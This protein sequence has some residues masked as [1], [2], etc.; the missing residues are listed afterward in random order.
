MGGLLPALRDPKAG[1][2]FRILPVFVPGDAVLERLSLAVAAVAPHAGAGSADELARLREDPDW[3]ATMLTAP[4]QP[5]ALIVVD[6]FEEVFTLATEADR[7]AL[8]ASLGRLLEADAGHRVVLT[9]REE[10]GSQVVKL[11]GI[12]SFRDRATYSMRPL[13]YEELVAAVSRPAAIVNLQFQPGIVDDLVKKVLGQAAA[14]PLLQFTLRRLWDK[15]DR[16]RITWEVYRA[17]KDP[18]EALKASADAFYES[19][20][21]Q[22]RDEMKRVLLELVRVDDFLEAYRQPLRKAQLL[23]AGRANTAEVLGLLAENDYLRITPGAADADTV[24]EIKHESLIRNWPRFVDW[25][26]DKRREQRQRMTLTQAAERWARSGRPVEGLLTGWQLQEAQR[27]EDLVG[28]DLEFVEA[29]AEAVARVQH[30]KE[31]ALQRELVKAQAIAAQEAQLRKRTRRWLTV[32]VAVAVFFVGWTVWLGVRS[33][34]VLDWYQRLQAQNEKLLSNQAA[35]RNDHAKL[36]AEY[37]ALLGEQVAHAVRPSTSAT[38]AKPAVIHIYIGNEAQLERAEDIR[39]QLVANGIEV[40]SITVQPAPIYTQVRYFRA[41]EREDAERIQQLLRKYLG[42][43]RV[44]VKLVTGLTVSARKYRSGSAE[45]CSGPRRLPPVFYP[46]DGGGVWR[47]RARTSLVWLCVPALPARENFFSNRLVPFV[48]Y[49]V[50]A[51]RGRPLEHQPDV[52]VVPVRRD[53]AVERSGHLVSFGRDERQVSEPAVQVSIAPAQPCTVEDV[54]NVVRR[55]RRQTVADELDSSEVGRFGREHRGHVRGCLPGCHGQFAERGCRF[56]KAL[57]LHI[58]G[59]AHW[60]HL[61]ELENSIEFRQCSRSFGGALGPG[62][63]LSPRLSGYANGC[64]VGP[65]IGLGRFLG[66]ATHGLTSPPRARQ[67]GCKVRHLERR[68]CLF[69]LPIRRPGVGH[70]APRATARRNASRQGPSARESSWLVPTLTLGCE[71][72][73]G[74][75]TENRAS[76]GGSSLR[77]TVLY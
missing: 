65:A 41:E 52:G 47:G 75:C 2:P 39:S 16:N 8:A 49:Q 54:P 45:G 77:R 43:E 76:L 35:L 14:L 69:V 46:A 48:T 1:Q 20:A 12:R 62:Q 30:E 31:E 66:P 6:Q 22:T 33:D 9:M 3:L 24:V 64:R 32:A 5:P 10:F 74:G 34:A 29:S 18:L 4:G 70:C 57:R 60:Q 19:L 59:I 23:R 15:R 67:L 38:S 21:D 63:R 73:R 71:P 44:D 25:I 13:G 36:Q 55:N 17:V 11:D 61:A 68:T 58:R 37:D 53:P 50:T 26:G 7:D 27:N 56:S 72:R 28:L 51:E 40:P 42:L